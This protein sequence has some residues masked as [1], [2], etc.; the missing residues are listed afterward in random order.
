MVH[1]ADLVIIGICVGVAFGILIASLVF[2]GIRWYKRRARLQRQAN[3]RCV[4]TLPIRTNGLNTSVD[5]SAS[6][7]SSVAI[8]TS[9]FPATN[10]QTSWW[11]HPSKDHFAS[12]SGIPRYSYKD[13]QK[14]T[15]NFTTILGQGSF[16]P[17]YKATMPAGGVVAVKVLATD[18]KQGEKEFF[19]EVWIAC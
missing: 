12:A 11:S 7:S 13:I 2:F 9:G 19:T 3:E 18:S 4:A 15:Q 6:L 14:A 17:V 5:F 16:G 10:S 8:K 1:K